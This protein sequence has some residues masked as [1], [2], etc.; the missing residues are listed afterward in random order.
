MDTQTN[1]PFQ[2]TPHITPR[3]LQHKVLNDV[4][5]CPKCNSVFIVEE[6]CESCGFQF[7]TNYLGNPLD[8]KSFYTLQENYILNIKKA[9]FSSTI[10]EIREKYLRAVWHR[11]DILVEHFPIPE[12]ENFNF[13][14]FELKSVIDELLNHKIDPEKIKLRSTGMIQPAIKKYISEVIQEWKKAGSPT[15]YPGAWSFF[16]LHSR[17]LRIWLVVYAWILAMGYL[18]MQGLL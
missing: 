12:D 10:K 7:K 13:F 3:P 11:F 16:R 1:S 15:E 9:Y 6:E 5:T 14:S 18:V 2:R 4:Q 8:E 17:N